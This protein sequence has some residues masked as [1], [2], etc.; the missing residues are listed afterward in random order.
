[1]ALLCEPLGWCQHQQQCADPAFPAPCSW[2]CAGEY[3][4]PGFNISTFGPNNEG[5]MNPTTNQNNNPAAAPTPSPSPVPLPSPQQQQSSPAPSPAPSTP[6]P[7]FN[8]PPPALR[9]WDQCGGKGG[10]CAAF[11]SSACADTTYAGYSCPTGESRTWV[12]I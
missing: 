4:P 12:A 11:G 1:L 5:N 3:W 8:A 6:S 10:N 7:D 9:I 2:Q